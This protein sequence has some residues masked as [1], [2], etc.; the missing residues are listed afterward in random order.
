VIMVNY[1]QFLVRP[2]ERVSTMTVSL[3]RLTAILSFG[4][5]IDFVMMQ[6]LWQVGAGVPWGRWLNVAR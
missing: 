3:A 6:R 5:I 1:L 4:A 2:H